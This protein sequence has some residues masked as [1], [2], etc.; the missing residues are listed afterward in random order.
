MA[1]DKDPFQGPSTEARESGYETSDVSIKGLA[2][3]L[4]CLVVSAAII[5]AGVWF[6]FGGYVRHDESEDRPQAALKDEQFVSNY[7]REHGT[8]FPTP[9]QSI[10]PAPRIQPSPGLTQQNVPEADLQTM[11]AGEDEVFR[12]MGWS[13][14]PRTHVQ[15]AIPDSVVQSVI[16]NESARQKSNPTPAGSPAEGSR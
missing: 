2:I 5:H 3:F 12:K 15:L 6:L 7:N 14:E 11:Y 4:V 16:Q 8:H 1:T 13:L 9:T 10:P